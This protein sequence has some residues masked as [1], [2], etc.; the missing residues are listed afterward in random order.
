MSTGPGLGTD[1]SAQRAP[2]HRSANAPKMKRPSPSFPT[3]RHEAADMHD[4][5]VSMLMPAPA[6]SGVACTVQRRPSHRSASVTWP[7]DELS[8]DPTAVHALA[9]TQDTAAR[10]LIYSDPRG[11]GVF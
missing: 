3:A 6:G 9:E 11:I 10:S 2:F 1:S 8:R 4:T 5:S 7:S